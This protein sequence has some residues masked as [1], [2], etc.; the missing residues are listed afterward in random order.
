MYHFTGNIKRKSLSEIAPEVD[1][2]VSERFLPVPHFELAECIV[3]TAKDFGYNKVREKWLITKKG[4]NLFGLL[5]LS[6]CY[7]LRD[8]VPGIENK[9]YLGVC[10]RFDQRYA[11]K[12]VTGTVVGVCSNGLIVGDCSYVKKHTLNLNLDLFVENVITDTM[13]VYLRT[14]EAIDRLKALKLS[15]KEA[16]YVLYKLSQH[17]DILSWNHINHIYSIYLSPKEDEFKVENLWALYNAITS[18]IKALPIN[19]QSEILEK[20]YE[21]ILKARIR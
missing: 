21:Y 12:L 3:K 19:R 5:E 6:D 18:F 2:N 15:K 1:T 16:L 10:N 9:I 8:T 14:N 4:K 11:L 13:D 17:Y 20:L 7:F